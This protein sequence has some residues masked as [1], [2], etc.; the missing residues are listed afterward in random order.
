MLRSTLANRYLIET[1]LGRGGMG[2]VY[3]GFDSRLNR[4]VAIKVLSSSELTNEDRTRLLAEAQAAAQLNHPNVVT[5][6]DALEADGQPFIVME[7]IEGRTLRSIPRPTLQESID[8]VRQIC[9]A[10]A[11]AHSKG[12]IHRDLKPEN[13]LLTPTGTVK[14]MDFGLARHVDSPRVTSTGTLMGTFAYMA[15]ELIEGAA[16]SPQSDLY[17][18]GVM[19]YEFLTGGAPFDTNNIGRLLSQHLSQQVTPPRELT[20]GIPDA[21]NT[22]VVQ[23][24]E[25]KPQDRPSS[26]RV[27]EALLL[28]SQTDQAQTLP[29]LLDQLGIQSLDELADS[30][31]PGRAEWEKQWRRKSYPR[32]AVPILEPGEKDLILANRSSELAR[33]LGHLNDHRLLLITG[34]PGVGKSTLARTLLEFMPPASPPP[35]WYDFGRQQSSGNT[36]GVLLDRISAYLEMILGSE[37][38]DDILSFRNSPEHQASS[39]DVDVLIDSLNQQTPLWLIFDNLEVVLAR[40]GDRFLDAGLEMLFNGLK[41]N[42]HNARI[43]ISSLFVPR[44][45]DGSYLLEFGTHPLT[46]QG[47]D[48]SSAIQ[49]LRTYGLRDFPDETLATIARRLD[50][51]PFALNHAAH[52]VEALGMQAALDNLKG[53]MEEFFEHLQTSLKQRLSAEE[54]SVLQALT[55]LQRETSLDG[56][57]QTGQAK[58]A[59]IKRLREEGLLETNDAGR[60]WLSSIVRESLSAEGTE[61]AREAHLRAASFYRAQS[62]PSAPRRID[63]FADAL[64][65]HHH[66]IQAGDLADAYRAIFS[67]R[68]GDQLKQWNE[69]SLAAELC[70]NIHS[71]ISPR[72]NP[73]S[74]T[75]WI[76]LNHR[77]G[78]IYFLL[79][80]YAQSVE[81]LQRAL[82]DWTEGESPLLKARLLIDLAESYGS[83]DEPTYAM[84]LCEQGLALVHDGLL[85]AKAL[86]LHGILR[87]VLGNYPDAI[88]DLEQARSIYEAHNQLTGVAYVTGELGIVH[89][90]LN[91]FPQALEN[92]QRTTRACEAMKDSRGAMI[93]H[94]NIGD[95]L[96]QQRKYEGARSELTTALGLARKKKLTRDELTAGLYLVETQIELGQ[97]NEAQ[98]QMDALQPLLVNAS[99]ACVVGQAARL[100][101]DLHWQAGK[102]PDAAEGFTRALDFLQQPGCEYELARTHLDLARFLKKQSRLDEARLAL[103]RAGKGFAALNNL[104]GLEAVSE[105]HLKIEGK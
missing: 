91:Q 18:L 56:L 70:E 88:A 2:I 58:P 8:Y 32:S 7:Y 35:F 65:W 29:V 53:G 102:Y 80:R 40:G 1:E 38:R 43:V 41:S 64:E 75:E 71:R 10:L 73:L 103:V 27:V 37:V 62:H 9:S 33:A 57:C 13:A 82:D 14:L 97:L 81:T 52:Y 100:L 95:V 45:N 86:Q 59:T 44:L 19:L 23:L 101:A 4:P 94:L 6:Y 90:Y 21:L 47:L 17:A 87:R 76:Q 60:F 11:H 22:L 54:F 89:Y 104:L 99:S 24:M 28:S 105:V 61:L 49:C 50:G 69:F 98:A 79:G 63:D 25:K 85:Y 15:P 30:R 51:H 42:T 55:V 96:L 78:V 83:R 34:M 31:A 77:L 46:L 3:R 74:N 5:V 72:A 12:I 16:P 66:A 68:L 36:L 84:E 26:A 20:S 39:Y 67:N 92:Y 93:G 48:T